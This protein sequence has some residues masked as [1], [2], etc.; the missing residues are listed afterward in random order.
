MSQQ[1]VRPVGPPMGQQQ[2][3]RLISMQQLPRGPGGMNGGPGPPMYPSAHH[4]RL[5]GPP[6]GRMPT[7]QPRLN[8]QQ[9]PAMMQPQ[10]QRQMSLESEMSHQRFRFL[11]QSGGPSSLIPSVTNP[12]NLPCLPEIPPI[13]LEDAGSS[14]LGHLLNRYISISNAASLRIGHEPLAWPCPH[15][16]LDPQG[17]QMH[18]HQH[19]LLARPAQAAEAAVVQL[20]RRGQEV[21]LRWSR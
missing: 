10:L 16:L 15:T 14:S 7:A 20:E 8:G 6:Q 11:L 4:M 5:Q 13:Q 3:P 2:P 1:Q 17:C 9:Y 21:A 19:D 18:T 12:E